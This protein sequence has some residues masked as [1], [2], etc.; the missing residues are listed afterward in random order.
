MQ[1]EKGT[2][3][4]T[5]FADSII[6]YVENSTEFTLPKQKKKSWNQQVYSAMSKIIHAKDCI[7]VG[8]DC[9]YVYVCEIDNYTTNLD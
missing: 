2:I 7:Y 4:L 8:K 3:K 1:M 6:V 9:M 5:L